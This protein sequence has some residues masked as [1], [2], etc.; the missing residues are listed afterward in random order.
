MRDGASNS[1]K[2]DGRTPKHELVTASSFVG[3]GLHYHVRE[4]SGA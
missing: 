4:K 3:E 1:S 2:S